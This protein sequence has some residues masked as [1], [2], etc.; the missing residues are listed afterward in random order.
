MNSFL[1]LT[2]ITINIL[3]ITTISFC[4]KSQLLIKGGIHHYS[5]RGENILPLHS[6]YSE[7]SGEIGFQVGYNYEYS[8]AEKQSLLVGFEFSRRKF[9]DSLSVFHVPVFFTWDYQ[10]PTTSKL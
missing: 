3:L 5:L 7:K 1:K 6:H 9:I 4:Q 10:F 8:F 2:L